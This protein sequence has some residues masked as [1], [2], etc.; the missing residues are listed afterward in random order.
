LWSRVVAVVVVDVVA[1]VV[2][3]VAVVAAVALNAC[4]LRQH[5]VPSSCQFH[6]RFTHAFFVQ[7]FCAKNYKALFW[8][9]DFLAPKLCTKN[10]LVKP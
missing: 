1:V 9:R 7:N 3:V 10:T 2:A 4:Q 8:L 6:Q 5:L